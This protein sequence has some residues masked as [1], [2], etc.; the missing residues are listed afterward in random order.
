MIICK[1]KEIKSRL[2]PWRQIKINATF[3]AQLYGM[4]V[5]QSILGGVCLVM[6]HDW[7][8]NVFDPWDGPD[9]CCTCGKIGNINGS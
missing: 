6:G 2:P 3:L 7:I 5:H 9:Y 4:K 1:W 8:K